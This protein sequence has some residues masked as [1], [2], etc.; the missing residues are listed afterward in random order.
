[1]SSFRF[2]HPNRLFHL[3]SMFIIEHPIC[4]GAHSFAPPVLFRI[5]PCLCHGRN[6]KLLMI[7]FLLTTLGVP[8]EFPREEK[9]LDGQL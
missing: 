8:W 3:H 4:G 7:C 6:W 2:L 9:Q 5:K 1:M